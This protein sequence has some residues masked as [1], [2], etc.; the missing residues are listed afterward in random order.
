MLFIINS[1]THV[2]SANCMRSSPTWIHPSISFLSIYYS[3]HSSLDTLSWNDDKYFW[4]VSYRV[5]ASSYS[6]R[7]ASSALINSGKSVSFTSNVRCNSG[8]S[9]FSFTFAFASASEADASSDSFV[10]RTDC[11]DAVASS[12]FFSFPSNP[13]NMIVHGRLLLFGVRRRA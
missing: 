5:L 2:A 12:S 3:N 13:D 4:F 9:D 8:S 7:A 1:I 11:A 10:D 6:S